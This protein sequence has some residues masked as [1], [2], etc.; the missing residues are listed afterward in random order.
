MDGIGTIAAGT[1]L[2]GFGE[3]TEQAAPPD[4]DQWSRYL[5]PETGKY[6]IDDDTSGFKR[7][8]RTRQRVL[9]ALLTEFGSST[10][11]P[12]WG[13]ARPSKMGDRFAGEVQARVRRALRRLTDVERLIRII[14]IDVERGSIRFSVKVRYYD[15]TI[16]REDEAQT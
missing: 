10:V 3:P 13:F 2:A 14:A 11:Q 5:N 12:E 7:M 8:P 9:L 1:G 6:E 16:K 4:K 15:H